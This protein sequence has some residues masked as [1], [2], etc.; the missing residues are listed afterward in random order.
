MSSLLTRTLRANATF[1]VI[2]G[3]VLALGA[4]P[5]GRRVEVPPIVVAAIGAALIPFALFVWRTAARSSLPGARGVLAADIAW[6]LGA[7]IVVLGVPDTMNSVGV[8]ALVLI[9]VVVADFALF[10]WVGLRR[11][12]RHPA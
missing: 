8:S 3:V 10:E 2:S 4:I 5:I 6:V 9:T 12:G 7:A 11:S 1:S